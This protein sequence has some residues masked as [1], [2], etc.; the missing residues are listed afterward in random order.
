[1]E[2]KSYT[3]YEEIPEKTATF[4]YGFEHIKTENSKIIY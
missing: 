3:K 4:L 1:M 2:V